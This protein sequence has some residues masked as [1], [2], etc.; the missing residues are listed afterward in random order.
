LISYT[1]NRNIGAQIAEIFHF[2]S[3][4]F[5]LIREIALIIALVTIFDVLNWHFD[6]SNFF[7]LAICQYSTPQNLAKSSVFS[8]QDVG[9]FSQSK[10][11][12]I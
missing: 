4:F 2:N 1:E 8:Q 3:L 12:Y 6:D 5:E 11:Y 7:I 9:L 10:V